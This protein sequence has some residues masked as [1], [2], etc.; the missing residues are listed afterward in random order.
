MS[1]P[2]PLEA[3]LF[4]LDGT[5]VDSVHDLADALDR[6]LIETGLPPVGVDAARRMVGD[7]ARKTLERALARVGAELPHAEFEAAF[8]RFLDIY[9]NE[10]G[11]TTR[12]YPGARACLERA[13]A[14]GILLGLVTNKPSVPTRQLLDRLELTPLF[15]VVVGGGDV[16]ELKPHPL[17]LLTAV[18]A[19][20][21]RPET[22]LYVGDS[23]TDLD[24]ARAAGVRI[25][26]IPSGYGQQPVTATES[27]LAVPSLT[28]LAE[29]LAS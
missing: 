16:A 22:A 20:G 19:L 29:R 13:A 2:E 12:L 4:D 25:A 26:L 7:G 28:A 6:L 11:D 23:R 27:D 1:L 5:L 21:A 8:A 9:E 14:S 17:P 10:L 18:R 24:T 15:A 3:V